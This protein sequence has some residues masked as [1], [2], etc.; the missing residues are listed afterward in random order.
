MLFIETTQTTPRNTPMR[1]VPRQLEFDNDIPHIAGNADYATE[2]DLLL[3]MDAILS[4]SGIEGI[5]ITSFLE[6]AVFDKA[7]RRFEADK[8]VVFRLTQKEKT[9]VQEQAVMALRIALLRKHT[10]LSLR[11][12]AQV[13]SH[14]FLYQ[15]FCQINRFATIK[16]PG[17]S[18]I[19]DYEKM[20]S[21]SLSGEL[22][23]RLL[24]LA[25]RPGELLDAPVD[26]SECFM[27]TTCVKANIHF[28]VD[29]V[30]I[31][32][33]I[34]TLMLAVIRI[35]KLGLKCRMPK[36]PQGFIKA[37]NNLSI[38]MTH[39]HRVKGGQKRRKG[40]LREM[41]NLL[42]VVREHARR[43]HDLLVQKGSAT[44]L[45]DGQVQQLLDQITSVIHQIPQVV[46]NAHE[47]I[48]GGRPVANED[49]IHSLYDEHVNVIVRRK[50]GA[51][52]EFGNT[53]CS[54]NSGRV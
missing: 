16:I 36:T 6:I 10:G 9:V 33:A 38:E 8:P 7:A 26:L 47:R 11:R 53:F 3:E 54:P 15:W 4:Q 31:R 22:D 13:L 44:L 46:K 43:H 37:I 2:K 17:K 14:S 24:Q 34:R 41:K 29:W 28:P 32:D 20:I 1:M 45:S 25:R 52:V 39:T 18:T 12:F 42:K 30:L 19:D 27:D 23:R 21:P 48:I 51:T 5:V 35:R 49:K 40:L 50:A